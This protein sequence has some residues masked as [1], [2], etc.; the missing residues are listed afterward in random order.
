V[1]GGR[2]PIGLAGV[3]AAALA[4]PAGEPAP[5]VADLAWMAG[6]WAMDAGP[7]RVEEAWSAPA[8]DSMTGM[9]RFLRNG[10]MTLFEALTIETIEGEV[11]MHLLH[12][13]PGLSRRHDDPLVYRLTSV[14]GTSAVFT[15]TVDDFPAAISY[16]R[17]TDTLTARLLDGEGVARQVFVYGLAEADDQRGSSER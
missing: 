17:T 16:A 1:R 6:S 15:N 4:A 9:C 14:E 3:L 5:T 13:G 10:R 11:R 8:A 7:N 2:L 12:Y